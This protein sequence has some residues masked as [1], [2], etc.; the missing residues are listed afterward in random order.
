MNINFNKNLNTAQW[1]YVWTQS[2]LCEFMNTVSPPFLIRL[3]SIHNPNCNI[4]WY[5]NEN[6]IKIF[7]IWKKI[8]LIENLCIRRYW[9]CMNVL[10]YSLPNPAIVFKYV[11]AMF[12][13]NTDVRMLSFWPYVIIIDVW[14]SW[15]EAT[16]RR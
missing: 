7:I 8:L 1:H 15:A 3:W 4:D 11:F 14:N 16:K 12:V 10:L 2:S 9:R 6:E 5:F 13:Y